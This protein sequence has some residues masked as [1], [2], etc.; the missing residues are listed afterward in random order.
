[1]EESSF[2]R[3]EKPIIRDMIYNFSEGD[4]DH[5]LIFKEH[6]LFFS[7]TCTQPPQPSS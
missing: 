1:M 7:S 5:D 6:D 2:T 3:D 4:V